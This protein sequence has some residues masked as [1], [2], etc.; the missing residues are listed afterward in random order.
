MLSV[1]VTAEPQNGALL[2]NTHFLQSSF[3]AEFKSHH[4]WKSYRFYIELEESAN[5]KSGVYPV[6]VLVRTFKKLFSLAYMPLAPEFLLKSSDVP[7]EQL[8]EPEAVKEYLIIVKKS[9]QL[10]RN[11]LQEKIIF[12]RFDPPLAYANDENLAVKEADKAEFAKLCSATHLKK[13]GS[14]IQPPDTV[15][16]N[17]EPDEETLLAN[18]KPKWRYN[19]RLAEKKGVKIER[20]AA[21]GIDVFYKLYEETSKRDGIA[22]HAK[23]YYQDLFETAERMKSAD[24]TSPKITMYV[25]SFEDEPLAAIITLFSPKE[26][27]YLYGASSNSHRN[28]MPAYLLQ[29]T[30]IQDAK[31]YGCKTYDFYGIPPTDDEHHPMYGLYRF[32]TGFGGAVVHRAGSVDISFSPLYAFYAFAEKLRLIWF[33]K[34]K[35]IFVKKGK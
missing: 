18:M 29:W 25:A 1:N 10:I 23:S 33:K 15:L 30:A 11:L 22:L 3:W 13:A 35:K 12:L 20:R 2:E 8:N 34:I 16:L 7:F 21:D 26:A 5:F 6:S 24:S 17:L 14:D 19:V 4:G 28:L 32:K 27:V 31:N 9:V